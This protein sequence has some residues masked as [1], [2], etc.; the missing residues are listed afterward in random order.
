MFSKKT[1]IHCFALAKKKCTKQKIVI[2]V[3]IGSAMF[4]FGRNYIG[5]MF[6]FDRNKKCT[7]QKNV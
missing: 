5:A 7:K 2:I 6:F 3:I 1:F 4:F